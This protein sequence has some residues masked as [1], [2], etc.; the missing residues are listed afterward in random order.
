MPRASQAYSIPAPPPQEHD[1]TFFADTLV[2][3]SSSK[4]PY[5][6]ISAGMGA[7][8]VVLAVLLTVDFSP[9]PMTLEAP[10]EMAFEQSEEQAPQPETPPE[11]P[12]VPE[13]HPE[14]PPPVAEKPPEPAPE[15]PPPVPEEAA[16]ALPV[17]PPPPPPPPA[18][19]KPPEPKPEPVK[20]KPAPKRSAEKPKGKP[21]A[22]RTAGAV[23]SDYANKV[24]QRI[25]RIASNTFPRGALTQKSVRV[26]YVIVIGA[27]GQ[28]ISKSI[29]PSGVA[30]VDHAVAQ[31][32]AQSAPFPPPP[33]LGASSYRIAGGI[34][35]RVR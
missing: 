7:Y 19:E 21:S 11:P 5:L 4:P 14:P 34:V 3:M 1:T 33:N 30:A 26:G 17:Q 27:S 31:A 18:L 28:L 22:T 13:Q 25:N 32:L 20:E 12:P 15:P 8:F 10:V 2:R 29:S 35:Y 24:F 23:P 6:F 9:A 16:E